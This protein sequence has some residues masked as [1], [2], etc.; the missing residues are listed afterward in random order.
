MKFV[1]GLLKTHMEVTMEQYLLN[2]L[3][4]SDMLIQKRWLITA[5][6]RVT[7]YFE[8][9]LQESEQKVEETWRGNPK[10]KDSEPAGDKK[11]GVLPVTFILELLK[12]QM[13]MA[14][15]NTC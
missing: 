11:A 3:K 15:E 10:H 6:D 5:S 4:T 2:V 1:L 13:R 14:V 7:R 9:T 8:T 12:T